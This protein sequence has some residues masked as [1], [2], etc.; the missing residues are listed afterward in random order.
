MST[1]SFILMFFLRWG[2]GGEELA[3]S[4]ALELGVNITISPSLGVRPDASCAYKSPKVLL[5][6]PGFVPKE[7]LSTQSLEPVSRGDP[8]KLIDN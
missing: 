2:W 8:S 1:F 5:L 7:E 3:I 4:Q 6:F